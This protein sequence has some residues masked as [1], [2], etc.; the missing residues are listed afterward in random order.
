MYNHPMVH[1]TQSMMT[2]LRRLK[3]E[4]AKEGFIIDGIFGSLARGEFNESSDVDLLY[5]VE[6]PF[7]QRYPGLASLR[8][9]SE[10]KTI[11][12]SKLGRPVDLAPANNLTQT[13]RTFILSELVRV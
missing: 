9:L 1:D 11:L 3:R 4:L 10:I 2:H 5:H 8:R 13:G 6:K 12:T 7:L